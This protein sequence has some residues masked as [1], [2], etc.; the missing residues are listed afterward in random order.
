MLTDFC[1]NMKKILC[2]I[3]TCIVSGIKHTTIN[4][5]QCPHI[6]GDWN[7]QWL[8]T[9]LEDVRRLE[10]ISGLIWCHK[11]VPNTR[12]KIPILIGNSHMVLTTHDSST[13][14]LFVDGFYSCIYN[15]FFFTF[16]APNKGK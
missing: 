1:M 15:T 12:Q 5:E 2:L 3:L 10:H 11:I 8:S 4:I 14:T 6:M 9:N 13:S 16:R 7:K